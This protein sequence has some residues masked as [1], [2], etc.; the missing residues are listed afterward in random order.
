MTESAFTKKTRESITQLFRYALVGLLSN[1]AGYLVY[2]GLTYLGSTPKFTM[3]MLYAIG[4]TVGFFG[5]KE[6][7]FGYQG[8]FSGAAL[9]YVIAHGFGYMLNLGILVVFVDT[10]GFA[11]Q[12]I[13][14]VAV[15]VVAAFL[16]LAFKLFVFPLDREGVR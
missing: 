14:G 12:W 7:T 13:Q 6:L 2:L 10:L 11:H 16:F 15:F 4:A 5:N 9:R 8:S 1:F 3:T